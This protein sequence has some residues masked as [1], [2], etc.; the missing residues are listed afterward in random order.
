MQ[1]ERFAPQFSEGCEDHRLQQGVTTLPEKM[2]NPELRAALHVPEYV[3]KYGPF[4]QKINDEF[5]SVM[6]GSIW[7]Y[8]LMAMYGYRMLHIVGDVDGILS[9]TGAW[10]W[11]R[12]LNFKVT[13]PW[14][15]WFDKHGDLC[16]Y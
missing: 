11:V 10:S 9:L 1:D 14:T 16:G 5:K 13:K 4:N 2:N 15:P 6:E 8:E 3:Q 7:I 12:K